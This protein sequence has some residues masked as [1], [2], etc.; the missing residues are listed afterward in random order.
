MQRKYT[1]AHLI[2]VGVVALFL[3][4]LVVAVDAQARIAFSSNRDGNSEIYVMDTDGGNQRKLTNNRHGD[5]SPSWSPDGKRIA[6]VSNRD[7]HVIDGIPT[8]DI[9][10]MD[11]DG[12]NQQNLTNNPPGSDWFP[13]WSPDG[14]RIVFSARR[15]GHFENKFSITNEIYVMDA[16]GGNQQRLTENRKNDW[17]P[18]WSPD[19]KRIAFSSD[20]KGDIVNFEIYVMDADGQNEQ[21][22]TENRVHDWFP[23]WS[24]DGKRIAFTSRRDG[25]DEIYVMD[26]DGGN[27]RRLTHH[28]DSD[29]DPS[30][31][32]DG[33]RIAFT[34]LRDGSRDIYVMDAD[35]DNQRNLTN[36]PDA[37]WNPSW[38]P[39]GKRIAFVSSR[40]RDL[41]PDIYVMDADGSNPRNLTNH[42]DDDEDPAWFNSP[43]SVSPAGKKFTMWG[44]FKQVD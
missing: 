32:P 36:H 42:P 18:S 29:E 20:R 5:W 27:Q 8:S 15:E 35:G 39:D 40:T 7:G 26:A 6:F 12:G 28:D 43:F 31:S 38:S 30:W 37:D 34:S 23:S 16:D 1:L 13:S 33:K 22:L 41:N 17:N 21:R 3:T 19:G 9:Y 2:L 10:V 14:K 24:P 11:A 4:P 25:N 44:W